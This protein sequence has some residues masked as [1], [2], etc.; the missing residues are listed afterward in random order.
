MSKPSP[1]RTPEDGE[2]AGCWRWR[3]RMT[4]DSEATGRGHRMN[5]ARARRRLQTARRAYQERFGADAP[6][7]S[8]MGH[9]RVVNALMDTV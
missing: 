5:A 1:V 2:G 8:Y 7:L 3:G 4:A 6:I 9:P